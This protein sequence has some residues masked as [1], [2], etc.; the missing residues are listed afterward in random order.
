M[1][2]KIYKIALRYLFLFFDDK[3]SAFRGVRSFFRKK[4]S[5]ISLLRISFLVNLTKDFSQ[6]YHDMTPWNADTFFEKKCNFFLK[7]RY[8]P[9]LEFASMF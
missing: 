8:T 3:S 7:Y 2:S 6:F 1:Y 5:F 9:P 4:N